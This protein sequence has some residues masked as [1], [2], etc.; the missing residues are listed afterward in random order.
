MVSKQHE[1][2]LN[3]IYRARM[4]L[5]LH[6]PFFGSLALQC[7]VEIDETCKT[8]YVDGFTLGFNPYFVEELTMPEIIGL[9]AHEIMH[10]ALCHCSRRNKRDHD[11]WNEAGDYVI[12][13]ILTKID[14][15]T[16][17]SLF[18]LPKGGLL[19]RKYSEMDADQV[20][21]ALYSK[22]AKQ[23]SNESRYGNGSASENDGSCSKSGGSSSIQDPTPSMG[24]NRNDNRSKPKH[25]NEHSIH[26]TKGGKDGNERHDKNGVSRTKSRRSHEEGIHS[27]DSNEQSGNSRSENSEESRT[28]SRPLKSYE[29]CGECRDITSGSNEPV[30]DAKRKEL[31]NQ[32]KVAVRQATV[33]AKKMGKLPGGMETL[34]DQLS[35]PKLDTQALLQ[36][37]M[38]SAS[39]SDYSYRRPNRRAMVNGII[40]PSLYSNDL[41]EI[42]IA[43]DTSMSMSQDD[44]NEMA[45][46][47]SG[48]LQDFSCTIHLINVDTKVQSYEVLTQD[49]LPLT[50]KVTG[51]GGTRF[52]DV[53]PYLDDQDIYPSCLLFLSD[54]YVREF[55]PDNEEP[56]FPCILIQNNNYTK[57]RPDWLE[58]IHMI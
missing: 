11:T 31:E 48:I 24:S 27:D 9:I 2:I 53:I 25:R 38:D 22:K 14:L 1:D 32:I 4:N 30:S 21:T 34:I 28:S 54:G 8:A 15:N 52:K 36:R 29:S 56:A 58:V 33:I 50:L 6:E 55:S 44:L 18:T 26:P 46:E 40:S 35:E 10:I 20:Y 49:D 37:F 42:A 51:G 3:K 12:N 7:L 17:K 45:S 19:D 47:I 43:L 16:G 41:G 57:K 13:L 23:K 5:V 39:K